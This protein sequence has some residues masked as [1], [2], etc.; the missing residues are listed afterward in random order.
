MLSI[1]KHK[2]SDSTESRI[3]GL[4]DQKEPLMV[5]FWWRIEINYL[6]F[7]AGLEFTLRSF[8]RS[9]Q[10]VSSGHSEHVRAFGYKTLLLLFQSKIS[11]S[12]VYSFPE[13]DHISF[14]IDISTRFIEIYAWEHSVLSWHFQNKRKTNWLST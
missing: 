3:D 9:F 5:M 12:T 8:H 13:L 14:G 7:F 4:F 10:P 2:S 6:F 11:D 1:E